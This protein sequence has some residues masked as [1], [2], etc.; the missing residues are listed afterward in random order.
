MAESVIRTVRS[1]CNLLAM[2]SGPDAGSKPAGRSSLWVE[3]VTVTGAVSFYM[4]VSI[5]LVFANK[6]LL[7]DLK[8]FD[9]PLFLTW[10]Q[11]VTAVICC[12]L[13][14][15]LPSSLT[16]SKGG[17]LVYSSAVAHALM[18]LC[19]IFIGM[20]V[21][22]NLCLKYVH[23][24]F[25]QVARSM[26]ILFNVLFVLVAKGV[27]PSML[28]ILGCV[29][30]VIGFVV[31][32]LGELEVSLIGLCFG[33][34]SSMFVAMYGIAVSEALRVCENDTWILMMYNNMNAMLLMPLA[35]MYQE[36]EIILTS[37][38]W[39]SSFFWVLV[40]VSG[41]LGFLINIAVFLQIK[42]TSP[43]THN[44]SGTFKACLQTVLA[45]LVRHESPT[46][47]FWIGFLLTIAGTSLYTWGRFQLMKQKGEQK[48]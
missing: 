30:V 38:L 16:G 40:L 8:E 9:A 35:F 32:S 33:I 37:P 11:L 4:A 6:R 7:S 1:G 29:I 28:E 19:L 41:V 42:H 36:G 3:V 44:V 48:G 23:I 2:S 22:N 39:F 27:F 17:R 26:T 15:Y 34:G 45:V 25:Y 43:L 21:L 20:I 47:L 13:G 18:P 12:V 5:L 14:S 31:G 10:T 24:S 46:L